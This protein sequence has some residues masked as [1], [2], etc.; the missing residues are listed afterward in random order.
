[1]AAHSSFTSSQRQTVPVPECAGALK[2]PCL[3]DLSELQPIFMPCRRHQAGQAPCRT[4]NTGPD[5]QPA[6]PFCKKKVM[7]HP[8]QATH[9]SQIF[10]GGAF[11]VD[12]LGFASVSGDAP[13]VSR[14]RKHNKMQPPDNVSNVSNKKHTS[15]HNW[16]SSA[17]LRLRS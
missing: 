12:Q 16:E 7:N 8:G 4:P 15:Q 13:T 1:M 17:L 14:R 11:A 2:G 5:R 3:N 6:V 9:A 10:P